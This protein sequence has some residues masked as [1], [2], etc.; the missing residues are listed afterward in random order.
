[1]LISSRETSDDVPIRDWLYETIIIIVEEARSVG[2]Q[3][4]SM[5][6]IFEIAERGREED[7]VGAK[8]EGCSHIRN[9]NIEKG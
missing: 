7:E 5:S 9:V 3:K 1:M 8:T 4:G 6:A 2:S